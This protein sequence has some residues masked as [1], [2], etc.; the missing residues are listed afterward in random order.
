V[1]CTLARAST[2]QYQLGR[3]RFN[4]QTFPDLVRCCHYAARQK[5]LSTP[6]RTRRTFTIERQLTKDM[7]I[8]GSYIFVGAHHLPHPNDINAPRTDL[9]I[10]NFARWSAATR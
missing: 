3:Q 10:S 8:S 5:G 6:M 4:D 2:A 7:A 1:N 9:Q